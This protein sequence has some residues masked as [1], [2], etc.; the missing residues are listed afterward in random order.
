MRG[1]QKDDPLSVEKQLHKNNSSVYNAETSSGGR[2]G[3]HVHE[4]R[5]VEKVLNVYDVGSI[6]FSSGTENIEAGK[7]WGCTE[8]RPSPHGLSSQDQLE[9][10]KKPFVNLVSDDESEDSDSSDDSET[11][12][13]SLMDMLAMKYKNRNEY[14]YTKWKFEADMLSSLEEDPELNMSPEVEISPKGSFHYSDAL[15]GTT[16]GKF[17]MDGDCKVGLK[18]SLTAL[19]AL[20]SKAVDDC[21]R[22]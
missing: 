6:H 21:K 3:S 18:K 7:G 5:T 8:E 4:C 15:R 12:H 2:K 14:Q 20:D 1:L 13:G 11:S 9:M 17:L 16:L 22:L 10:G 19:E